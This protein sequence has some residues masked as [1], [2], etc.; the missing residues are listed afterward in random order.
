MRG[1]VD[2]ESHYWNRIDGVDV[3]LTLAQFGPHA[4]VHEVVGRDRDYV[5]SF[6]ETADRYERL[7]RRVGGIRRASHTAA[8]REPAATLAGVVPRG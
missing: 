3:D 4:V 1:M 6:A 8:G 2:G 5:L 7:R